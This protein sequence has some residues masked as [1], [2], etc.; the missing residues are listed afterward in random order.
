MFKKI[1]KNLSIILIALTLSNQSLAQDNV[2][3]QIKV[4]I[5]NVG[6]QIIAIANDKTLNEAKKREKI[7]AEID[8]I[9]D[10]Q[11]IAKF[12][13]GKSYKTL[14][15]A[16]K[17]DFLR[18]YREFMINTYGP[19]F[20]NYNGKKFTVN[21]I[22]KQNNFYIAHAEFIAKDSETPILT[23][24]RVRVQDGKIYVLDFIAEGI[25]LIETQ[26]SEFNAII[27]KD[28][29]EKFLKNLDDKVKKLKTVKN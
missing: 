26:R 18:L 9:I 11:W 2:E 12:V 19:K 15:E 29:V 7:I 22:E 10:S 8:K 3:N 23:D 6:N 5:E 14:S 28:G 24:F 16:Q 1:L 27:D 13:L 17:K 20:K 25:S 4:F 21:D